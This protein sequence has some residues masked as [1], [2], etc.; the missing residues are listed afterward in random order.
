M[1]PARRRRLHGDAMPSRASE[2]MSRIIAESSRRDT[3]TRASMSL[4]DEDALR[5]AYLEVVESSDAREQLIAVAQDQRRRRFTEAEAESSRSRRWELLVE[6]KLVAIDAD[7]ICTIGL[8]GRYN[9]DVELRHGSRM[10]AILIPVGDQLFVCD[11]GSYSGFEITERSS[12]DANAPPLAADCSRPGQRRVLLV[13]AHETAVLKL[14][15]YNRVT[16][17]PKE[18]AVCMDEPRAVEF[19]ECGHFV[20]CRACA[21]Q[22]DRCPLCRASLRVPAPDAAHAHSAAPRAGE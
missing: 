16:I 10:H 18:C 5:Q 17:N 1:Q 11:V 7:E 2:T 14:G 15:S 20:C 6:K 4:Q 3:T 19:V 8:P 22:L 9:N 21:R 13:G 12:R